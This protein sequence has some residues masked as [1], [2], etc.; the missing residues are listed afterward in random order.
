MSTLS[1][2]PPVSLT[3]ENGIAIIT[4]DHPPINATSHAVRLG[5]WNALDQVN[6]DDAI[7]AAIL[8]C[9]IIR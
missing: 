8:I 3:T 2:M 9:C 6:R 4:I 7:R 1:T 5:I